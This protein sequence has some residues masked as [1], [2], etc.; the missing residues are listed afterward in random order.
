[1]ILNFSGRKKKS[2]P[3][4]PPTIRA[5]N[6]AINIVENASPVVVASQPP[7]YQQGKLKQPLHTPSV[8]PN[9]TLSRSS[10]NFKY[11]TKKGNTNDKKIS[12][13]LNKN[14][15]VFH[16]CFTAKESPKIKDYYKKTFTL[17]QIYAKGST[18]K[19]VSMG[20]INSIVLNAKCD[21]IS[22]PVDETQMNKY[23][24]FNQRLAVS[25]NKNDNIEHDNDYEK[26]V[27]ANIENND[28]TSEDTDYTSQIIN[29]SMLSKSGKQSYSPSISKVETPVNIVEAIAIPE[30]IS[31]CAVSEK[32]KR[33][34]Y[35]IPLKFPNITSS[36][37]NKSVITLKS[38]T[39]T[40]PKATGCFKTLESIDSS[41]TSVDDPLECLDSSKSVN[42]FSRATSP[43]E[44]T[45]KNPSKKLSS[46]KPFTIIENTPSVLNDSPIITNFDNDYKENNNT[47][48]EHTPSTLQN[49]DGSNTQ[50]KKLVSQESESSC[51]EE[52]SNLGA[53]PTN[54]ITSLLSLNSE[55]DY[56]DEDANNLD[57]SLTKSVG[58]EIS[59]DYTTENALLSPKKDRAKPLCDTL[60]LS[61]VVSHRE[62]ANT[63][64]STSSL[65]NIANSDEINTIKPNLI[66]TGKNDLSCSIDNLSEATETSNSRFATRKS[67]NG[68]KDDPNWNNFLNKLDQIIIHKSNAFV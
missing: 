66:E 35:F 36:P 50:N 51:F 47:I 11:S 61:S 60:H 43:F 10:D 45:F 56:Y 19:D 44:T 18:D 9:S 48:I 42:I 7:A 31:E 38:S 32:S 24:L 27:T 13:M 12:E 26:G 64:E 62:P 16:K 37:Y 40:T 20:G 33:N 52:D 58:S 17:G 67:V 25:N 30:N 63:M 41:S 1:M 68:F 55:T 29:T 5:S 3:L 8:T 14:F 65:E 54:S 28:E 53:S 23:S 6:P 22:V 15:S 49:V 34:K 46:L 4:P 21:V 39:K 57:V 59:V 2:A